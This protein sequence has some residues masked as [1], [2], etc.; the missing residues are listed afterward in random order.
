M[1]YRKKPIVIDTIQYNGLNHEKISNFVGKELKLKLESETAYIAGVA[2]PIFSLTIKTLEGNHKA[3]P[4]DFIIKG[5]E[6]EFYPCKPD[7][8]EKTYDKIEPYE[9]QSH[10]ENFCDQCRG[11]NP[12]WS[13]PTDL[14]NKLCERREIICPNCFQSRAKKSGIN[15]GF[16]A[17]TFNK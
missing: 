16:R 14:W 7:I 13:A 2:P 1:K 6:G 17:E 3:M 12:T 15:V 11:K 4:G 8:F 5:I 10:P 9:T